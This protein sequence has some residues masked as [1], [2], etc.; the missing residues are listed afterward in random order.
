MNEGAGTRSCAVG[1][2]SIVATAHWAC[3]LAVI[4]IAASRPS[5]SSNLDSRKK[6]T[7]DLLAEVAR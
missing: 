2:D 1:E 3:T 7:F 5:P 4:S 6:G